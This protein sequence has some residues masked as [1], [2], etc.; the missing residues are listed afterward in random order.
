MN[1]S[2]VTLDQ[3]VDWLARFRD[4][5]TEKQSY[6]TELDSAIGDAAKIRE[7]MKGY[8]PVT[9]MKL[10]DPRFSP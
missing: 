1:D 2:T 9:E 6:L 3:L 7:V 10:S 8:G 4:L 5:V